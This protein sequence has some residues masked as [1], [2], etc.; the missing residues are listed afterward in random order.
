MENVVDLSKRVAVLSFNQY[1]EF[2]GSGQVPEF[3]INDKQI[4]AFAFEGMKRRF[5]TTYEYKLFPQ[6]VGK[7]DFEYLYD[8]CGLA[9]NA[10]DVPAAKVWGKGFTIK[11][12][13]EQGK[14]LQNSKLEKKIWEINQAHQVK[15]VFQEAHQYA[16]L[17]GLGI[18][19]MGLA[20]NQKLGIKVENP[21]DLSYLRAFSGLEVTKLEF[22]KDKESETYGEIIKYKVERSGEQQQKFDVHASRVIHLNHGKGP[23]GKSIL[24]P[25]YDL[26]T[27]YKNSVWSAGESYYQNASPLFIVSWDI[28]ELGEPPSE[29]ELDDIQ[30][31]VEELHVRKRFVKPKGFNPRSCEGQ[32]PTS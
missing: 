1:Q 19:V 18:V 6:E 25:A 8:R 23:W 29:D 14:E 11:V 16:R 9:T 21:T 4:P 20:D 13:D 28:D 31:D 15:K 7:K 10:V 3:F 22:D 26:F 32:R 12:T 27:V 30:D 24:E 17:Y 5:G 2:A